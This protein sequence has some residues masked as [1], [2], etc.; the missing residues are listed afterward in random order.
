MDRLVHIG[1]KNCVF[2]P[3][4]SPGHI[5]KI[6][7]EDILKTEI[8]G[9]DLMSKVDPNHE[10]TLF[11]QVNS[12][13]QGYQF[14]KRVTS[15][16]PFLLN[17]DELAEVVME[18]GGKDLMHLMTYSK[19]RKNTWL[20]ILK[21]FDGL[22]QGV[23]KMVDAKISHSDI[24]PANITFKNDK[25]FLIDAGLIAEFHKIYPSEFMNPY[26]FF[27]VESNIISLLHNFKKV[28]ISVSDI[29][30]YLS[31]KPAIYLFN[32]TEKQF[33]FD[34]YRKFHEEILDFNAENRQVN[35][36]EIVEKFDVYG[37]AMTLLIIANYIY[38]FDTK[39][40]T[41]LFIFLIESKVLHFNPLKRAT[42]KESQRRYKRFLIMFVEEHNT[43]L[44]YVKLLTFSVSNRL[45]F[46]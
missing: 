25:L 7:H 2:H 41:D 11:A 6:I 22:F 44:K 18:Y 27:P 36:V 3:T 24:K 14:S 39:L 20:S 35:A 26:L 1:K 46:T 45:N 12:L 8:R 5:I 16:C 43:I 28:K 34:M 17:T 40:A 9:I 30:D 23:V 37:L 4:D 31:L 15:L 29:T 38:A 10:F 32:I 13:P 42:A 19:F 21:G 33:G